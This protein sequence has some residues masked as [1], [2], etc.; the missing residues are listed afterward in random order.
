MSDEHG[1]EKRETPGGLNVSVITVVGVTSVLLVIVA[2]YAVQAWYYS[3]EQAYI[4]ETEHRQV[5]AA[6]Q[7]YRQEQ[8][9]RLQTPRLRAPEQNMAAIPIDRAMD[10]YLEERLESSP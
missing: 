8:E 4:A 2:V 7:R 6:V 1:H 5:P 3:Y 10:L 9:L